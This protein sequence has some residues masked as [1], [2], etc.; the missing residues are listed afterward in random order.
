MCCQSTLLS[1]AQA[2]THHYMLFPSV[3]V[4]YRHQTFSLF[5]WHAPDVVCASRSVDRMDLMCRF[6][7]AIF[8][9]NLAIDAS[10]LYFVV[11]SW[12]LSWGEIVLVWEV[13]FMVGSIKLDSL[14]IKITHIFRS[15]LPIEDMPLIWSVHISWIGWGKFNS[16]TQTLQKRGV[17]ETY[18][19]K[20]WKIPHL[21]VLD[22][23]V[24]LVDKKVMWHG[25]YG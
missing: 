15:S 17:E 23:M 24:N 8:L 14:G 19:S 2:H 1:L 3:I 5:F 20:N 11:L 10:F 7:S 21:E 12:P 25:K 9:L 13:C 6:F 4:P 22:S 18:S 16:T